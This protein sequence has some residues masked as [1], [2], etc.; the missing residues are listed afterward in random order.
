MYITNNDIANESVLVNILP[1]NFPPPSPRMP[2]YSVLASWCIYIL[3]QYIQI[4]NY[5]LIRSNDNTQYSE[6][7]GKSHGDEHLKHK[8]QY[9]L[10]PKV[11]TTA[12]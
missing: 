5:S 1:I 3:K 7:E 12:P 11:H 2:T 6:N 10:Q 8:T 4:F 9:M